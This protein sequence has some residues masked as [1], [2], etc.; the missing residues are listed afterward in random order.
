[1]L[2]ELAHNNVVDKR[3]HECVGFGLLERK[4]LSL[5]NWMWP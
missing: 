1:M 3:A 4:K 2:M 5:R